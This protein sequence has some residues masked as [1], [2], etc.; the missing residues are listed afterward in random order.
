[1]AP[2]AAEVHREWCC[3][4]YVIYLVQIIYGRC[5]IYNQFYILVL[6]LPLLLLVVGIKNVF[7]MFHTI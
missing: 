4:K 5:A 2:A 3:N 6:L 7:I 1:M